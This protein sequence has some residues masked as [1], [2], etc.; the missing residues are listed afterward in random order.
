[1]MELL[2]LIGRVVMNDYNMSDYDM[3]V[4]LA[5]ELEYRLIWSTSVHSQFADSFFLDNGRG[6]RQHFAGD[7]K[8]ALALTYM[9]RV[10]REGL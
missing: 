5:A 2:C 3:L 1:M 4:L 7:D 8:Y 10:Y 9:R 6:Q